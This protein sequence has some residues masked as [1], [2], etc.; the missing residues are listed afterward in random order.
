MASGD[1]A[2]VLG[3]GTEEDD[4]RLSA[5]VIM[6]A[7]SD[8]YGVDIA[9]CTTLW[10]SFIETNCLASTNLFLRLCLSSAFLPFAVS[11]ALLEQLHL[12]QVELYIF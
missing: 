3:E 7:I 4:P 8:D 6:M 9:S 1:V 11:R 12:V 2:A 10:T 5:S